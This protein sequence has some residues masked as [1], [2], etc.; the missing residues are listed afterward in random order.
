MGLYRVRI[1]P[2]LYRGTFS[3]ASVSIAP[4]GDHLKWGPF[5]CAFGD[6]QCMLPDDTYHLAVSHGAAFVV[7][8]DNGQVDCGNAAG[9]RFDGGK[10]H[11]LPKDIEIDP[12]RYEGPL[13][14]E[15]VNPLPSQGILRTRLLPGIESDD[16]QGGY[17]LAFAPGNNIR[18]S[19][20]GNGHIRL[21]S[22]YGAAGVTAGSKLTLNTVQINIDVGDFPGGWRITAAEPQYRRGSRPVRLVP[23][24]RGFIVELAPGVAE[25]F[26][27][28]GDGTPDTDRITIDYQGKAW[29]FR[30]HRLPD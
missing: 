15:G 21:S 4:D 19:V 16:A 8:A 28:G 6:V 13:Q 25:R 5:S 18:L 12:G 9:L 29:T 1:N 24:G 11:F 2:D 20:D 10:L 17:I 22:H 14:I 23:H 3:F 7:K 27:L 26:S 30:L